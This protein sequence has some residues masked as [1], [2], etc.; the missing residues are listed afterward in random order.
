ML[1]DVYDSPF[2]QCD[3][4]V[5]MAIR[6]S[7]GK[8]LCVS[9]LLILTTPLTPGVWGFPHLKQFPGTQLGVLQCNSILIL[10]GVCADPTS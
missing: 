10:T 3:H 5:N 8:T 2:D 7:Q 1:T 4:S 9:F 6:T